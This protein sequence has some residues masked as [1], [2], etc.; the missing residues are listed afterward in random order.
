M[1]EVD[2]RT[3]RA[4]RRKGPGGHHIDLACRRDG[5]VVFDDADH[6]FGGDHHGFSGLD[7]PVD[8]LVGLVDLEVAH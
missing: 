5:A 3:G 7:L 6:L 8:F 4:H 1:P 2:K